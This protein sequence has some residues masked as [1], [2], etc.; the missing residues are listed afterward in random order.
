MKAHNSIDRQ[1]C[2]INFKTPQIQSLRFTLATDAKF[3]LIR[4][5]LFW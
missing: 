1:G 3:A 4:S 5:E 2:V